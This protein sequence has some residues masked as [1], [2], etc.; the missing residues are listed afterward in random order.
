[1]SPSWV[2]LQAKKAAN[3]FAAFFVWAVFGPQ[4][5]PS[6]AKAIPV[7]RFPTKHRKLCWYAEASCALWSARKQESQMPLAHRICAG[8]TRFTAQ[9]QFA[10][11]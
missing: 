7:F 3:L 11:I 1:L 8:Q 4:G 6:G 9:Y 5:T 10:E 2:T